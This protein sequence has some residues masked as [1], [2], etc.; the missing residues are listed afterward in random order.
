MQKIYY[1]EIHL[2]TFIN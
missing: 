1:L 2:K